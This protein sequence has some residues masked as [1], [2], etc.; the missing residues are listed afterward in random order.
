MAETS[1][2]KKTL[3][4]RIAV[5]V[6]DINWYAGLLGLTFMLI[7]TAMTATGVGPEGIAT[8]TLTLKFNEQAAVGS[9]ALEESPVAI[10]YMS[11]PAVLRVNEKANNWTQMA[12]VP[13]SFLY[14][15]VAFML[16][17]IVRTARD[18]RPFT[19]DN[20]RRVRL[21]GI[22]IVLY[23]PLLSLVYYLVSLGYLE[24]LKIPGAEVSA[25]FNVGWTINLPLLGLLVLVLAQVF[26]MGVR[27][28]KDSDLTV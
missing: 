11:G 26:D 9:A 8:A 28:Q 10:Q 12:V 22:I 18:G 14:L 1:A 21:I 15:I 4:T 13:V 25:S 27:L 5:I 17:K 7:E 2:V 6:V 16:R 20:V 24:Y 23:G 3:L 19:F